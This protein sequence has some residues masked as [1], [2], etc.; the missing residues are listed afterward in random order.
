M[1]GADA[2]VAVVTAVPNRAFTEVVAEGAVI[3]DGIVM[4]AEEVSEVTEGHTPLLVYYFIYSMN[5][6]N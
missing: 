1:I 2:G 5:E 4:V 3:E 6:I